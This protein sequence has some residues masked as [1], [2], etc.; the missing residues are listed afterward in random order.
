MQKKS[1]NEKQTLIENLEEKKRKL[2]AGK[3]H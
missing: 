1:G 3:R 2:G